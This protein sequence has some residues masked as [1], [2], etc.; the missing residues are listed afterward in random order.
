MHKRDRQEQYEE[1]FNAAVEL[2]D[3]FQDFVGQLKFRN[4]DAKV[5]DRI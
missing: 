2:D 1:N 5:R 3:Q 4:N